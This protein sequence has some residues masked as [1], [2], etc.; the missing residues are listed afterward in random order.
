MERQEVPRNRRYVLKRRAE[1]QAETRRRIVEAAVGFHS[2]V[3]PAKTTVTAICRAAGVRRATFYRHFP[4]E[5]SLFAACGAQYADRH[6]I[7]DPDAC[8]SVPEP[9]DRLRAGLAG[10]YA[11][12]RANVAAMAPIIHDSDILP[13]GRAFAV[14]RDRLADVLASAW[15]SAGAQEGRIRATCGFAADFRVWHVLVIG[16]GLSNDEAIDVMVGA[17]SAAASG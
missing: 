3:G 2:T 11:Y 15:G 8:A 7:P 13:T 10:A 4:D 9:L 5:R 17:V 14:Y 12:Y 6:P 1:S 16:Q